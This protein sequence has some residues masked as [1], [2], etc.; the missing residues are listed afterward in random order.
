MGLWGD[1][2]DAVGDAGDAVEDFAND[3]GDSVGNFFETIGNGISDGLG[4]L[5]EQLGLG[6][7][8]TW[9]GGIFK[10]LFSFIASVIK[11]AFGLLGAFIGGLIKIVGG[12]L[13]FQW[14]LVLEGLLNIGAAIAGT[15]IVVIGKFIAWVQAIVFLQG[16]ERPLTRQEEEDLRRVF[17]DSLNYYVIRIVEDHAGIFDVNPDPF[18]LGN[19]VYTK[20]STFGMDLLVHETVHVWQYQQTGN[21]YTAEAI[22]AQWFVEEAY[23]WEREIT[24]RNKTDWTEFNN[25]A[26][27]EFFE[28]VWD[29]GELQDDTGATV[30]TG[31]GAFFDADGTKTFG[32]FE[33]AGTDYTDVANR[34]VATVRNEWF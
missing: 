13:T 12:I 11:A 34:V 25:E 26:Q 31:N 27:A 18:T 22:G 8:F 14:S 19:T 24:N 5:G 33:F 3:V 4:W 2:K 6:G 7:F 17:R 10:G 20:S 29:L 30:Q 32:Y 21:R 28:D 23:D 16:L 9:L 1:V 15:V